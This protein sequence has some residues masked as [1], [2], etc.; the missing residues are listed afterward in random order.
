MFKLCDKCGYM[1]DHSIG[2]CPQCNSGVAN[3]NEANNI[4]YTDVSANGDNNTDTNIDIGSNIWQPINT[5]PTQTGTKNQYP[6]SIS[7]INDTFGKAKTK[8]TSVLKDKVLPWVKKHKKAL[9]I[10]LAVVLVLSIATII[11]TTVLHNRPITL[12]AAAEIS[13]NIITDADVKAYYESNGYSSDYADEELSAFE[14]QDYGTGLVV[15]GYNKYGYINTSNLFNIVDWDSLIDDV[16]EQLSSRKKVN[17]NH[18][19]F[20]DLYSKDSIKIALSEDSAKLN[21]SL[22]NGDVIEIEYKFVNRSSEIECETVTGTVSYTI[23]GLIDVDVFDP[24][25][26]V[27]FVQQGVNSE[28]RGELQV[29]K[30]LDAVVSKKNGI[31]AVYYDSST[32]NLEKD[33]STIGSISFYIGD[34]DNM[35]KYSNGDSVTGYCSQSESLLDEYQIYISNYSKTYKFTSLGDYIT[36]STALKQDDIDMFKKVADKKM[37]DYFA[38]MDSYSGIKL[39]SLYIVDSNDEY[40]YTNLLLFVYSYDYEHTYFFDDEVEKETKYAYVSFEDL[41]VNTKGKVMGKVEYYESDIDTG[42]SDAEALFD[43][44]LDNKATR[45]KIDF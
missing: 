34:S 27:K 44:T 25:T 16:N 22:K 36:G 40:T 21:N 26:C 12:N 10:S 14:N 2:D 32:V 42:F 45:T 5:Q 19:N 28:G 24:F 23:E 39:K 11:T 15:N 9:I 31:K 1:Y 29:T 18:L 8:T 33:G 3:T 13:D 37:Q 20:Y 6:I 35:G 7:S 4:A 43:Y 30:D 41:V 17:G 38:D